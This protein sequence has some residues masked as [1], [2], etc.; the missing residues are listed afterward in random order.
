MP[1]INIDTSTIKVSVRQSI[2]N[3]TST[4]YTLNTDA[5]DVSSNSEVFYIQEGQNNK[6]EIY[7]G[8]NVLGKKIPDLILPFTVS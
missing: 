7:F 8:N 6:Y 2:S 1:D 5:L 4:V 3:L